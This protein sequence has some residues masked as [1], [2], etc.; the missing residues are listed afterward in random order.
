MCGKVV[1]VLQP[2]LAQTQPHVTYVGVELVHV[3]E[4]GVDTIVR[5]VLLQPQISFVALY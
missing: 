4:V 1:E 3:V 2:H 5:E